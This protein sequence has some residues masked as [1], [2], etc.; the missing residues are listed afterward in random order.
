M[1]A[2]LERDDQNGGPYISPRLSPDGERIYPGALREAIIGGDDQTLE[3]ALRAPGM[4]NATESYT[5]NGQTRQRKM[6]RQA[7]QTLAEGEFNRYYIRGLCA[8]VIAEGGGAVE[9]YRARSSSWARPESE[10]LIGTQIDAEELLADLRT[11]IGEE[12]S[13]LPDVNSGLSV[14]L[15]G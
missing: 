4:L 8:R 12:P 13:L 1:L 10:A 3:E 14:R 9:V 15:V 5:R 6:N 7:P 11:H 2:E